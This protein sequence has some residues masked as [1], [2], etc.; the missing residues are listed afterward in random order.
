MELSTPPHSPEIC[1]EIIPPS[2]LGA[3]TGTHEGNLDKGCLSLPPLALG[4]VGI[5]SG[6][7]D[8]SLVETTVKKHVLSQ[9]PI[10]RRP[11][12]ETDRVFCLPDK[13]RLRNRKAESEKGSAIQRRTSE[14]PVICDTP[15]QH[16]RSEKHIS[17]VMLSC[18]S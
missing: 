16:P 12:V 9:H 10:P 5:S 3:H 14:L 17:Q 11:S 13:F 2:R 7:S 15:P 6:L 4:E 1:P 18:L 8:P